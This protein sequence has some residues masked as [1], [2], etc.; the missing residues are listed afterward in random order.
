M[1]TT[2]LLISEPSYYSCELTRIFPI[3]VSII[4]IN[5]DTGFGINETLDRKEDSLKKI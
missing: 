4:T 3:R 5:G 1:I 2:R